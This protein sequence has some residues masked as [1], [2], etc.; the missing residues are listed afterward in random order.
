[1]RTLAAGYPHEE[2]VLFWM[3]NE[4]RPQ[5][6]LRVCDLFC[7]VVRW[8]ILEGLLVRS[9]SGG[10]GTNVT[11]SERSV[12]TQSAF[13][14]RNALRTPPTRETSSSRNSVEIDRWSPIL[15]FLLFRDFLVASRVLALWPPISK[16]LALSKST[17]APS[18]SFLS[19]SNRH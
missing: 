15:Q 9:S 13:Q 5:R 7:K 19:L 6:R 4:R 11:L 17:R 12:F 1:M 8:A 2:Q 10:F 16:S 14:F 18:L 3:W